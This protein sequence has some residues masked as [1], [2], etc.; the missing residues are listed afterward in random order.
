MRVRF[1]V[2]E[3]FLDE[4]RYEQ[5]ELEDEIVRLTFQY[6]QS[7]QVHFVYAMS[8]V[9]GF[10][11]RGKLIELKQ[12]CGDVMRPPT[13][14]DT[15]TRARAEQIAQQIENVVEGMNLALRRGVFEP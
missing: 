5:R 15:K 14:A 6:Q 13:E 9:A 4:L 8:V 12:H 1:S 7:T 10:I 2:V 11:A 3:E